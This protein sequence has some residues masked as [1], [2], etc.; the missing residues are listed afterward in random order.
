MTG[1]LSDKLTQSLKNRNITTATVTALTVGLVSFGA[2][3]ECPQFPEVNWWGELTHGNVSQYVKINHD[4]K[5]EIYNSKWEQQ[6]SKL[7]NVHSRGAGIRT[8]TGETVKGP[9]LANYINQVRQRVEVNFCLAKKKA[10]ADQT[11]VR[12]ALSKLS[13]EPSLLGEHP[14]DVRDGNPE[15]GKSVA[16]GAGC[17]QCHTETGRSINPVVPNLA[18]QKPLYL[19]KQLMAFASS[20]EGMLPV[21]EKN[22]RYHFFM[23][24]K[25]MELSATD[26]EDIA[27]YFAGL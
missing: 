21:G 1:T 14:D 3:A 9:R 19:V 23:S 6:L 15:A 13:K 4:G 2:L 24:K 22:Y 7:T 18:G 10:N 5:W 11:D 17:F 16:Q 8:P 25:A 27:A 12:I 20:A 26:M